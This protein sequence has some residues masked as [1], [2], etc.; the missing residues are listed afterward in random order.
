LFK[1]VIGLF[2]LPQEITVEHRVEVLLY[3]A[4]E[5][6]PYLEPPH[7]Y[8]HCVGGNMISSMVILVAWKSVTQY[9]SA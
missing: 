9:I 3:K 5:V 7:Q 1:C 6:E 8:Y 2:G 4:G